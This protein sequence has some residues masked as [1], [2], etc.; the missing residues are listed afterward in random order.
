MS[1]AFQNLFTI[2]L[3]AVITASIIFFSQLIDH[4]AAQDI[5]VILEGS[6]LDDLSD[7]RPVSVH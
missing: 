7:Y 6:N 4:A 2:F 1:L 5:S 3:N